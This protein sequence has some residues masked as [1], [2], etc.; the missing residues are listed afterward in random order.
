MNIACSSQQVPLS[1]Q[2]A[3]RLRRL[4]ARRYKPGDVLPTYR[5]LATGLGVGLRSVFDGMNLLATQ[6]LVK[7]VRRLGTVVSRRPGRGASGIS[8]IAVVPRGNIDDIF[9]GYRGRILSGIGAH[10]EKRR[11]SLMLCPQRERKLVPMKEVL[12]SGSD[13]ILL[14]GVVNQEY[15][16][17][18]LETDLPVVLIDQAEDAVPVDA[19]VSDNLGAARCVLGHLRELGHRRIA[20]ATVAR[21]PWSDFDNLER[22]AVFAQAMAETGLRPA[23]PNGE[24]DSAGPEACNPQ[25]DEFIGR[26]RR[27]RGAPTALVTDSEWTLR[28]LMTCAQRAGL[29]VPEDLS[30]TTLAMPTDEWAGTGGPLT[31]CCVDFAGMGRAAVEALERRYRFPAA[32]VRRIRV[33]FVYCPG[34]TVASLHSRRTTKRCSTQSTPP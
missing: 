21:A 24:F 11:L 2:V 25:V 7:P 32:P 6:G 1:Q 31:G 14:V 23:M 16:R 8:Q 3:S 4:I 33:P 12:Q 13:A 27:Q 20:Y 34:Q 29:R 26:L 17:A 22:R 28:C 30:L 5:D 9:L 10:V 18:C 19:V 15:T